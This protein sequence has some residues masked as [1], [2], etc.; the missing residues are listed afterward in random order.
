MV[1]SIFM[2]LVSATLFCMSALTLWWMLHA[3]RT[4]EILEGTRFVPSDGAHSLSFS[5]LVPARHEQ[6]GNEADDQSDDDQKN[7]ER[8]HGA[9]GTRSPAEYSRPQSRGP[10]SRP[11]AA[12][13]RPYGLARVGPVR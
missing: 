8:N 12:K 7:Y 6:A 9:V 1:S 3:W 13:G 4:P 5:L 10:Q 2:L 11:G